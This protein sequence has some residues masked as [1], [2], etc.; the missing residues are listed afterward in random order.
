MIEYWYNG[1]T[2]TDNLS[3]LSLQRYPEQES[4]RPLSFILVGSGQVVDKYWMPAQND[5]LVKIAAIVS[6]EEKAAFVRRYPDFTGDFCTLS[7]DENNEQLIQTIAKLSH[8]HPDAQIALVIPAGDRLAVTQALL[9]HHLL[10]PTTTLFLEKPYARTSEE[11][12]AFSAL[13]DQFGDQLHFSG[14]YAT[15]RADIL[16]PQLPQGR[17][18]RSIEATLLEGEQYYRV[19]TDRIA[20]TGSHPY[21]DDGPELDLGFHLLDIITTAAQRF[22]GIKYILIDSATDLSQVR[23]DFEPSFGFTA[24]LTLIT[25]S[26]EEV[27]VTLSAG[28]YTGDNDRRI[29]F[30]YDDKTIQQ[31]YTVGSAIDPVTEIC[32]VGEREISK[33][34]LAQHAAG[35]RYYASELSQNQFCHQ[36]HLQ[37]QLS[38]LCGELAI[39]IKQQR[40][41]QSRLW[42]ATPHEARDCGVS[43]Q[44]QEVAFV[45]A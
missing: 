43:H 30:V 45:P 14:K 15:G 26:D 25:N 2:M 29:S 40:M 12:A 1:Y 44:S 41:A 6:L 4:F 36:D 24:A 34:Q 7:Q 38:L 18:P 42:Y 31:Q 13:L 37:Q 35:Y 11:I 5:G 23:E 33:K 20:R 21:L 32:H 28:K 16:Y 19:V 39:Q 22:G 8:D 10:N 9:E 27:P 3:E 17:V